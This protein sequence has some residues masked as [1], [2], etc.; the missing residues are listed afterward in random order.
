[1]LH[2][3][4]GFQVTV[5]ASDDGGVDWKTLEE[6]QPKVRQHRCFAYIEAQ[7]GQRFRLCVVRTKKHRIRDQIAVWYY[8]DGHLAATTLVPVGME[9][10]PIAGLET[11]DETFRP[12]IFDEV[13]KVRL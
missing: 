3:K 5:E 9:I 12:F 4:T 6:H 13:S 2:N 10:D 7:S 8:F 11:D 1:M